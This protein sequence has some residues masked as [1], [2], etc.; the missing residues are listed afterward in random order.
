LTSLNISDNELTDEGF[1]A[2]CNVLTTN[3][4]SKLVELDPSRCLFRRSKQRQEAI[5]ALILLVRTIPIKK[6]IIRGGATKYDL[7][8]DIIPFIFKLITNK[9]IYY[10]DICGHQVGDQ[11]AFCLR[12]VL[13]HNKIISCLLMD[14]NGIT[15]QGFKALKI[16]FERN[17][18]LSY[19][20]YPY[21]DVSY[22][23]RNESID[24]EVIL[25]LLKD[26]ELLIYRN[27]NLDTTVAPVSHGTEIPTDHGDHIERKKQIGNRKITMNHGGLPVISQPTPLEQSI[28]EEKKVDSMKSFR[29]SE[30]LDIP[31]SFYLSVEE[32]DRE[33]E[34]HNDKTPQD[35]TPQDKDDPPPYDEVVKQ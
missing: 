19:F 4:D 27:S 15:I 34:T 35:K 32:H 5:D 22:I 7:K 3:T 21:R 8:N 6:L 20:P 11:L 24:P 16:A 29:V 30:I 31:S 9:S 18:S 23:L 13:Q 17:F 1:T 28:I 10:L 2:L 26:I 25:K 33:T 12:K 14:E